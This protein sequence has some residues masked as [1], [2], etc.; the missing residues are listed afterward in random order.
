MF[1]NVLRDEDVERTVGTGHRLDVFVPRVEVAQHCAERLCFVEIGARISGCAAFEQRADAAKPRRGLV[2]RQLVP[3]RKKRLYRRHQGALAR[4]R[5]TT[6]AQK[7]VSQPGVFGHKM[8]TRAADRA[9]T[10]DLEKSGFCDT[11]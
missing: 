7:M 8:R 4:D 10:I 6:R 9:G 3:V 2:D 5:A 1:E 11:E